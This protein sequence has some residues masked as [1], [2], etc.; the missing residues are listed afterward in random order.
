MYY[1]VEVFFRGGRR[2]SSY[3]LGS[4]LPTSMLSYGELIHKLPGTSVDHLTD[5]IRHPCIPPCCADRSLVP[6]DHAHR[7]KSLFLERSDVGANLPL[8]D[9]E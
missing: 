3:P 2:V 8:T 1:Y 7:D 4:F 9:S 6:V 5:F